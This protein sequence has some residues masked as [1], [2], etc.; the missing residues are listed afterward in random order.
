MLMLRSSALRPEAF[1]AYVQ[2]GTYSSHAVG[3]SNVRTVWQGHPS[4]HHD[5]RNLLSLPYL[6]T[7]TAGTKSWPGGCRHRMCDDPARHC[8]VERSP[9]LVV[10]NRAPV[11]ISCGSRTFDPK[12]RRSS[13]SRVLIRGNRRW[14]GMDGEWW[15]KRQK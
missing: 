10:G 2:V 1:P 7:S 13:S 6:V 14:C 8:K 12:R 15:W 4:S 3:R 11:S 9:N 5:P